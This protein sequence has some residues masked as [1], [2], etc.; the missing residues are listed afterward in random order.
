LQYFKRIIFIFDLNNAAKAI[1]MDSKASCDLSSCLFCQACIPEWKELTALKKQTL[2]FKKG[3]PIFSEGSLVKGMFFT[4]SGAVKVHKQWVDQKELIIRFAT[5]GDVIGIRGFGD[6]TFR[7][8]ATALEPTKVCCIPHDHLQS[9]LVTN[10]A[11][12]YRL[13]QVYASELQR[14]EQR[15]SDLAHLGVK[16]RMAESLLML[17]R[18]FGL[19]EEG[20]INITISR[21]DIASYAGTIYETVFKIFTE[22]INAGIIETAGKRIRILDE[23]KLLSFLQ[24]AGQ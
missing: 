11:L 10:P 18:T 2:L 8:S 13:M 22:W 15:M 1:I 23:S 4:L 14:A 5:G 20:F 9:S 7:V 19:D 24:Q 12:S 3:E 16:G 6:T 17:K 21:Q